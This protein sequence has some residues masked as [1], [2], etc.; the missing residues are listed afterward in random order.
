[1]EQNRQELYKFMVDD[2]GYQK[3]YPD[4]VNAFFS[5]LNNAKKLYDKLV[6]NEYNVKTPENVPTWEYWASLF[7]CDLP[8]ARSQ[9][10]CKDTVRNNMLS[11][12]PECVRNVGKLMISKSTNNPIIVATT[13]VYEGIFFYTDGTFSNT[14]N[15]KNGTYE[16]NE[17][18]Q[19]NLNYKKEEVVPQAANVVKTQTQPQTQPTNQTSTDY[20]RQK[21]AV[22]YRECSGEYEY[23]CFNQAA[24]GK[25]QKC[26]GLYVTGYY[27]KTLQKKLKELGYEKFTD[28]D[29]DTICSKASSQPI[30][31]G[32]KLIPLAPK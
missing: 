28:K 12:F 7:C 15:K 3:S 2:A 23:G 8:W 9:S 14:K 29:I 24:I 26:L 31:E 4:F 11:Q 20:L 32:L 16:C 21:Y 22:P 18:G 25:L 17:N 10:Y 30:S 1:M 27:G 13:G 6:E 5:S 19:I